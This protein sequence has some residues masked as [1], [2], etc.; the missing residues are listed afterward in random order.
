LGFHLFSVADPRRLAEWLA[1]P[2]AADLD[3][4]LEV[5]RQHFDLRDLPSRISAAFETVGWEDW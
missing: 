2:S 4:N 1:A 3:A 5:A